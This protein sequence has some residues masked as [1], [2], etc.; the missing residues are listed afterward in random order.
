MCT[1]ANHEEEIITSTPSRAFRYVARGNTSS[2]KLGISR[3]VVQKLRSRGEEERAAEVE[4]LEQRYHLRQV[5]QAEA[6]WDNLP[7]L[8]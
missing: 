2:S 6:I 1:K 4:D 7:S 3:R 5:W 8:D